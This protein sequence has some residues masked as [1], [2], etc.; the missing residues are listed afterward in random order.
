MVTVR[1]SYIENFSPLLTNPFILTSVITK[2]SSNKTCIQK[3]AESIYQTNK[4][5]FWI[6]LADSQNQNKKALRLFYHKKYIW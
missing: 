5:V 6:L 3:L 1:R 4:K 2:K